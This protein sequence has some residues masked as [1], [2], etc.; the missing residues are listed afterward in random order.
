MRQRRHVL[1]IALAARLL[2]ASE[3]GAVLETIGTRLSGAAS[4]PMRFGLEPDPGVE[5]IGNWIAR[6]QA[7]EA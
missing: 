6:E 5:A 7:K 3:A 1:C 4:I 2:G